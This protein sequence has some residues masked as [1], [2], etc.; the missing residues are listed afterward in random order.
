M[1]WADDNVARLRVNNGWGLLG[2]SFLFRSFGL[3]L[4]SEL[5]GGAEVGGNK[6]MSHMDLTNGVF[7]KV[8]RSIVGQFQKVT[9]ESIHVLWIT[10]GLNG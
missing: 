10:N 3:F 9:I 4:I 8:G 2:Y 5:E 1:S 6:G 7:D